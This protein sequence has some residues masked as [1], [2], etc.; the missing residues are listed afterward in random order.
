MLFKKYI[1]WLK[2]TTK[3]NIIDDIIDDAHEMSRTLGY[4]VLLK[5]KDIPQVIKINDIGA[6]EYMNY[7][8]NWFINNRNLIIK[9][10]KNK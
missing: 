6:D 2:P 8:K 5:V 10:Y 9:N 4:G 1:S 7:D 3:E